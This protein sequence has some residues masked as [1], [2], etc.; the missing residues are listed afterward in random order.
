[1]HP[2]TQTRSFLADLRLW[3]EFRTKDPDHR[4]ARFPHRLRQ[5]TLLFRRFAASRRLTLAVGFSPR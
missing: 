5:N 4:Q 3:G 1:M 2:V